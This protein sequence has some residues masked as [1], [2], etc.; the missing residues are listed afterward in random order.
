MPP[1]T[2]VVFQSSE[3]PRAAFPN[4]QILIGMTKAWSSKSK[5]NCFN[6]TT[7]HGFSTS[8]ILTKM[9]PLQRRSLWPSYVN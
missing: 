9:S 4:M 5:I 3:Q 7:T 6:L 8:A 2:G 1:L